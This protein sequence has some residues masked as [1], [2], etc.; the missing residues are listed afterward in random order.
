[1]NMS[2]DTDRP[3]ALQLS[4]GLVD[5]QNKERESKNDVQIIK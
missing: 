4:I 2:N 1:M 5:T 3:G